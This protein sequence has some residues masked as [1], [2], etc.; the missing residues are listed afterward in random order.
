MKVRVLDELMQKITLRKVRQM[1]VRQ[2][3]TA[4]ITFTIN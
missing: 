2:S 4:Q 3:T 1:L